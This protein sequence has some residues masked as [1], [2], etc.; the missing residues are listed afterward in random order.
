MEEF[1]RIYPSKPELK[2]PEAKNSLAMTIFSLVIFIW[3]FF[4]FI[5]D[6]FRFIALIILVLVIHESGHFIAMKLFRYEQLKMIFLPLLGAYVHGKKNEYSQRQRAI[7]LLAGPIPGILIGTVLML[8]GLGDQ[9]FWLVYAGLLFVLIN[10]LNLLPID[11]L[12]GGQLLQ[13][14]LLGQQDLVKLVFSLV[15]SLGMIAIGLYFDNWILI[16]FGF[17]LGFRVRTHQRL[18]QM[19]SKLKEEGIRYQVNYQDLTDK[20][21]YQLKEAF[22]EH[23]PTI[24]KIADS[25]GIDDEELD[26]IIASDISQVLETPSKKDLTSFLKV[27]FI[28]F[29]L[30]GLGLTLFVFWIMIGQINW[31]FDAIQAGR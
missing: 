3:A 19:R 6:D 14:L 18:Y 8:F 7:V 31:F 12:D 22:L 30:F 4:T 29:W 2:E 24:K 13:V 5:S 23:S 21:Y 26:P 15:S 25:G 16:V 11:P 1:E 17:I 27:L 10:A 28:G 20:E 9:S